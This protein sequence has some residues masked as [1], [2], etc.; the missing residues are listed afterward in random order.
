MSG[1]GYVSTL[2]RYAQRVL[3]VRRSATDPGRSGSVCVGVA[4]HRLSMC[5]VPEPRAAAGS[6]DDGPE[7][8]W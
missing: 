3:S 6:S 7:G 5:S 1:E 4:L 8:T 2:R